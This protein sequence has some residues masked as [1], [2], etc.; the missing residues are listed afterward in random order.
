MLRRTF[1]TEERGS[2]RWPEENHLIRSVLICSLCEILLGHLM[3][4][5][6]SMHWITE[7]YIQNSEWWGREHLGNI[8]I[9][10]RIILK[11]ILH[12]F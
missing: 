1:F 9:V 6:C 10:W 12:R 2:K 11:C 7:K 4:I 5:T 3:V 8:W